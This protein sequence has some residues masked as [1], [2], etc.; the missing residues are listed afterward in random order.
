MDYD[1]VVIVSFGGPE[2]RE[3]VL[4]F[5]DNVLRGRNVPERRKLEVADHYYAMGGVSPIAA[6]TRAM[7]AALRAELEG[8]GAHLPVYIGCRNWRPLLPDTLRKMT[9]DGVRRALAIVTSAFGS[10]SGCRQYR[11][12]MARAQAAVGPAAPRLDKIR[13]FYNHPAFLAIWA[14]RVR[15]G[16]AEAPAGSELIFTAHSVPVAMAATGPYEEQ[17]SEAARLIAG[18]SGAA[19]FCVAVQS[20]SGPPSQPWLGPSLESVLAD[21]AARQVPGVVVAPLGFLSDHMEVVYDLDHEARQ[22]AAS[23]G[24][25][26]IR[27]K[28]PGDH[29]GFAALLGKLI[30]ERVEPARPRLAA[31]RL[32]PWPDD[33]DTCIAHCCLQQTSGQGLAPRARSWPQ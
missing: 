5:L 25:P 29:P 13:L 2:G 31:G 33:C 30:L 7:A 27:V 21:C 6:A 26:M 19:G 16:L 28:T 18:A 17:L 1:A 10:Y 3:D 20:R 12:D 22:Q 9:D 11:E 4:P 23:L 24:L 32:G 8:K 14:E 15:A